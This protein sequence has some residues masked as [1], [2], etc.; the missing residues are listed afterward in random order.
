MGESLEV[1]RQHL[2]R[3]EAFG[4]AIEGSSDRTVSRS[5]YLRDPN[6]NEVELFVDNPDYDWQTNS[7]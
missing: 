1:L 5:L 7:D 4:C 6:G 2:A 3:A